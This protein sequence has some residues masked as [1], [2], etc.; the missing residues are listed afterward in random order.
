MFNGRGSTYWIIQCLPEA[1][2]YNCYYAAWLL[3][4]S[5]VVS[6]ERCTLIRLSLTTFSSVDAYLAY[7]CRNISL[8][9]QLLKHGIFIE[10]PTNLPKPAH[11][12]INIPWDP[13]VYCSSH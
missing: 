8:M 12:P 5:S 2:L 3:G 10:G 7:M 4:G 1:A 13:L 11:I 9:N 6:T